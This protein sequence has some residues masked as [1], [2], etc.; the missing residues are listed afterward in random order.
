MKRNETNPAEIRN[1]I[2]TMT[3]LLFD[4]YHIYKSKEAAR[5]VATETRYRISN[6]TNH[7]SLSC[8]GTCRG[9]KYFVSSGKT[10]EEWIKEVFPNGMSS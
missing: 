9:C 1:D 8:S 2:D 6:C 7:K 10:F 5:K 3:T 4:V